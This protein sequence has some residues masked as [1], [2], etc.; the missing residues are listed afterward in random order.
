MAHFAVDCAQ[1]RSPHRGFLAAEKHIRISVMLF[2]LLSA[3]GLIM[4]EQSITP[5]PA[6]VN[7]HPALHLHHSL[8]SSAL[9]ASGYSDTCVATALD[10]C[11][12]DSKQYQHSSLIKVRVRRVPFSIISRWRDLTSG[13]LTVTSFVWKKF[14]SQLPPELCAVLCDI[15]STM[16]VYGRWEEGTWN[17]RLGRS[18]ASSKGPEWLNQFHQT[19]RRRSESLNN[20]PS[21]STVHVIQTYYS[22]KL[23]GRQYLSYQVAP[24]P[25]LERS[26]IRSEVTAFAVT[27]LSTK[28]GRN[29][30]RILLKWMNEPPATD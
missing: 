10:A 19:R 17:A 16:Y 14:L 6:T 5:A 29:T 12:P 2:V 3:M 1:R 23:T 20:F 30:S 9:L 13:S 25:T 8:L 7:S 26:T 11:S 21:G 28:L 15:I 4:A 18:H 24:H 27:L 22:C